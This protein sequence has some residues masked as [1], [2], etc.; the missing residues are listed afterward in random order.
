MAAA[1]APVTTAAPQTTTA[2]NPAPATTPATGAAATNGTAAAT[3]ATP[4][5]KTTTVIRKTG[6]VSKYQRGLMRTAD[7][8]SKAAQQSDLDPQLK[9]TLAQEA[10]QILDYYKQA[11]AAWSR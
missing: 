6:Y 10:S 4:E 8:M 1:T 3:T 11:L 5:P 2:S 9:Q 7:E